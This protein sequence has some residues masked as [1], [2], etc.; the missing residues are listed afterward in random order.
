MPS[1]AIIGGGVSGLS[2]AATL[3]RDGV[4]FCVYE[5]ESH[6]GGHASTDRIGDFQF[7]RGPHVLLDIPNALAELFSE[8]D[9]DL[10]EHRCSSTLYYR[11]VAEHFIDAP[12]QANI[13]RLTLPARIACT[14]DLVRS[15]WCGRSPV[16][17]Q[18][19]AAE[20]MLGR[21]LVDLFLQPYTRK[22][23]CRDLDE[24][25]PVALERI[26]SPAL[27]DT[28]WNIITRKP[29]QGG[30][31][32]RF[33]YPRTG[34]IARLPQ[35]LASRLPRATLR[36]GATLA[37]VDVARR[38]ATLTDGTRVHFDALVFS[39]P[40]TVMMTLI[41]DVPVSVRHAARQLDYASTYLVRLGFAGE[42]VGP[43]GIIRFPESD[44]PF[45]RLSFPATYARDSVPAGCD[46]VIAEVGH[47]PGRYRLSSGQA[48]DRTQN[49]LVELGIVRS[50]ASIAV[51]DVRNVAVSHIV[52]RA[53]ARRAAEHLLA[54]LEENHVYGC[55]K[56]GEWKDMLMPASMLSG[57]RVARH[58][59]TTLEQQPLMQIAQQ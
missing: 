5:K 47:H 8:L 15:K 26:S 2:C 29:A 51:A 40:L 28:I 6:V 45:Y 23:L 20:R 16:R 41:K 36:T 1:V 10:I 57:I 4:D 56:Y 24:L 30:L 25:D 38:F 54:W 33:S 22:R 21:R 46:S 55:G 32:S 3:A 11:T 44:F 59:A 49:A 58:V 42:L 14:V 52:S 34:G 13:H 9:I 7:D 37:E 31:D 43:R 48:L 12:I 19:D 17:N 27:R 39:L 53:N 50:A 35:A 18:R